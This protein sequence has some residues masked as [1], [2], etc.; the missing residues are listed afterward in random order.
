MLK[1]NGMILFWGGPY[2]NWYPSKFVLD[3]IEYNCSEQFMMAA[4]AAMFED[5]RAYQDIMRMKYPKDQKARGRTVKN[6]DAEAWNAV[7]V[8]LMVPALVAKFEQNDKLLV[9]ILSSGTDLIVEASPYDKIWGIGL[10]ADDPRALDQT[11]WL[12][13]NWLGIALMQAR[14]ILKERYDA[15]HYQAVLQ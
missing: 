14:K 13:T 15:G 5:Q 4:K 3:D 7:A 6:F 11:Q 10:N 8:E 9:E 2:S 12:G 1:K